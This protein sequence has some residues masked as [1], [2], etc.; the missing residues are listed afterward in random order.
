V[1]S[2]IGFFD[3]MQKKF[4]EYGIEYKDIENKMEGYGI[5]LPINAN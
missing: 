4:D 2:F 3:E 1:E 5:D